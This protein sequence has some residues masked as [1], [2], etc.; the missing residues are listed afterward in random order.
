ML[1]CGLCV[2]NEYWCVRAHKCYHS[3]VFVVLCGG[4]IFLWSF[5]IFVGFLYCWVCLFGLFLIL[6]NF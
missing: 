5:F 6:I 4:V 3:M 1:L 2:Y